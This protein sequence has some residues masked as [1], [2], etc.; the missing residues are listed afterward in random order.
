MIAAAIRRLTV[1]GAVELS[2]LRGLCIERRL[3]FWPIAV[4]VI[5]GAVMPVLC[6]AT[7]RLPPAVLDRQS[8]Y[9]LPAPRI[10]WWTAFMAG[11]WCRQPVVRMGRR[12]L[13]ALSVI[14]LPACSELAQPSEAAAPPSPPPYV[15]IAAN[16][17]MATLKDRAVYTDFEISPLRWVE[18]MKGW[19]WLACVHFQDRGHLRSYAIFIQDNAV[20]D[21][22]YAVETDSCAT[23]TYTQFDLVTGKLGQPTV[24]VQ[25]PLY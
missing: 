25:P 8:L 14:V 1:T 19:A 15:S 22:R 21:A 10:S 2:K 3:L 7:P 18:S 16:Y 11:L 17:L 13:L 24:P 20:A 12:V 6:F 9:S 4:R 23:Q 5:N